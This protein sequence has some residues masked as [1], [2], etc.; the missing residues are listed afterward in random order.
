MQ[1]KRNISICNSHRILPVQD[2]AL[3]NDECAVTFQRM[4][5]KVMADLEGCEGYIDDIIVYGNTYMGITSSTC[6]E[7]PESPK[8]STTHSEPGEK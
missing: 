5:H 8:K 4:I 6:S 7:F 2:Y 3:R 1:S